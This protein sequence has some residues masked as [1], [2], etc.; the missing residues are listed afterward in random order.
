MYIIIYY[1]TVVPTNY[2]RYYKSVE[3][4]LKNTE[5]VLKYACSANENDFK[6]LI[7]FNDVI[8]IKVQ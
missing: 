4:L 2:S 3:L 8:D 1:K 5:N 6:C 7:N